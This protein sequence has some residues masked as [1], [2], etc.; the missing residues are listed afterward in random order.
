MYIIGKN[1]NLRTVTI[2]DA[3][4][5]LSLRL[6]SGKNKFISKVDNDID[7]QV[8]WIENYKKRE[9]QKI[10]Y[11]F[12]IENNTKDSLGVVRLYDFKND[13]FSWGS[14]II[15]SGSPPHA[16]IESAL[17]IYEFSF[18]H[19]C[20]NSSH[21]DVRKENIKV[22]DFHKRLG[23]NIISDDKLNYYFKYNKSDYESIKSKY[24]KYL[25]ESIVVKF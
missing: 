20:F 2:E 3:E 25:P 17:L 24:K 18:N 21:F 13:S 23:A 6:D 12:V 14:W 1:I 11:Y 10:E 5:I 9:L 19:L 16:S 4:F 8:K 15:K 22:I 7:M